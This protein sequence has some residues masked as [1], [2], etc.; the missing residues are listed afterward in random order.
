MSHLGVMLDDGE[1]R[2]TMGL[3]LAGDSSGSESAA[4]E[5]GGVDDETA[6][7]LE[8]L[9]TG[10]PARVTAQGCAEVFRPHRAP[11]L[12]EDGVQMLPD[13]R[14][15]DGQDVKPGIRAE[16]RAQVRDGPAL[17]PEGLDV[18]SPA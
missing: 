12:L 10:G 11:A 4:S 17:V 3:L 7:H 14:L 16:E 1:G 8:T 18:R 15:E 2:G 9:G 13:P 5:G 6:A